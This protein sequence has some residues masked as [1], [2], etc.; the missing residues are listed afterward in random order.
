MRRIEE[1]LGRRAPEGVSKMLLEALRKDP[2]GMSSLRQSAAT[3]ATPARK[4]T[5]ELDES[6]K[7][8]ADA[9]RQ[10]L[11]LPAA[12]AEALAPVVINLDVRLARP[13]GAVTMNM[14]KKSVI[15]AE[16]KP[17]HVSQGSN[18]ARSSIVLPS[19]ASTERQEVQCYRIVATALRML[20]SCQCARGPGPH[21][22]PRRVPG[23]A[24]ES[25]AEGLIFDGD[26]SGDFCGL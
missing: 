5:E 19:H 2:V 7:L 12:E 4:P 25:E 13:G 6:A 20:V 10:M 8:T 24:P 23:S 3:V 15:R 21:G 17:V 9:E 14:Q 11:D 26:F 1:E 22:F 16:W 18:V